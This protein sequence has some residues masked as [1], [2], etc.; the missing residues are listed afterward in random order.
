MRNLLKLEEAPNAV[1]VC[2][3]KAHLQGGQVEDEKTDCPIHGRLI[4]EHLRV[5]LK[6][7][8]AQ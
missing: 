3:I 6:L 4:I 7:E 8:L 5:V 2:I 1:T